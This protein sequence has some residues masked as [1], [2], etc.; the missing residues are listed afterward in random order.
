MSKRMNIQQ[1]FGHGQQMDSIC[2]MILTGRGEKK[3]IPEENL[4]KPRKTESRQI[5]LVTL[6]NLS[7]NH[8]VSRCFMSGA[9]STIDLVLHNRENGKSDISHDVRWLGGVGSCTDSFPAI[10]L[11]RI[12]V[13]FVTTYSITVKQKPDQQGF[14]LTTKEA[15]SPRYASRKLINELLEYEYS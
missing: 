11:R 9:T 7:V 8:G 13:C 12:H 2:Q 15:W 5:W 10:A 3:E 4:L 6:W 1:M 14:H